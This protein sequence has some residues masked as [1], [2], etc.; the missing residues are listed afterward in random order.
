[1]VTENRII[2]K[3]KLD[4]DNYDHIKPKNPRYKKYRIVLEGKKKYIIEKK[5]KFLFWQ[6]WSRNYLY[7]IN[8]CYVVDEKNT[9]NRI[10][11]ILTGDK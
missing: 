5:Q 1:M 8:G 4:K 10:L 2:V 3:G 9:A 11:K 6:W 7:N